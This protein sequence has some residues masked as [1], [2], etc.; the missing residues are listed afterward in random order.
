MVKRIPALLVVVPLEEGPVDDPAER[1]DVLGYQ[2]EPL[3]QLKAKDPEDAGG[4]WRSIGHHQQQIPVPRFELD[5]RRRDL[6]RSE[7]LGNRR[8][9]AVV[10]AEC[11]LEA[12]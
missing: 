9:P 4:N 7:E 5:P 2:L 8:A 1:I 12:L 6:L 10:P 3:G 11:P